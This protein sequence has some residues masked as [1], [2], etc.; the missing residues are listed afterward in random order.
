MELLKYLNNILPSRTHI[1]LAVSGGLDS[2]VLLDIIQYTNLYISIIHANFQLRNNDSRKDESFLH[3]FCVYK[4]IPFYKKKFNT[5]ND[6]KK[7]IQMNARCMRY[8][9]FFRILKDVDASYIVLAHHLDDTIE[10]FFINLFRSSSLRGLISISEVSQYLLRPL[11]PFTR[12]KIL[13][14]AKNNTIWWRE[15]ISNKDSKY[16]RNTVRNEL[17]SQIYNKGS[18]T[19]FFLRKDHTLIH[20]SISNTFKIITINF[21]KNKF[22]WN[23]NISVLKKIKHLSVYVYRL[24]GPYGFFNILYIENFLSTSTGKQFF[25]KKYKLLND[26]NRLVISYKKKNKQEKYK[27]HFEVNDFMDQKAFVSI[28][29]ET[30]SWPISLRKWEKGD[31]FFFKKRLNSKIISKLFKEYKLNIFEKEEI[32]II[33]NADNKIIWII[34]FGLNIL[35]NITLKTFM[36]LNIY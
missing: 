36:I 12:T 33:L 7:S 19:L 18:K 17:I 13:Q 8:S 10:T 9:W 34:N 21:V 35:F 28:D 27:F 16:L 2:M 5:K 14:Y 24:F 3:D 6:R 1:L 15:D 11:L 26:R 4:K 30:I 20:Q 23:I 32:F 22:C 25:S 31:M 29:F